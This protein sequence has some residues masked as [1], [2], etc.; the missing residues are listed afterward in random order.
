MTKTLYTN[1]LFSGANGLIMR[2][3]R[4]DAEPTSGTGDTQIQVG[5]LM[6]WCDSNDSDKVYL[7]YNDTTSGIV[8]IE[9]T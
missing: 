5:E 4:Q 1:L 7:V 3:L 6:M 8:K 9:L 2:R